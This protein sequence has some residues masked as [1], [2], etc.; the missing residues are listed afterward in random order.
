MTDPTRL[1]HARRA[2]RL[3]FLALGIVAGVWGVHVPSVKATYALDERGLAGVLLATSVGSVLALFV[4]GRLVGRLGT[5]HATV[6]AALAFTIAL[7]VAL[8]LPGLALLLPVMVLFGAGESVYDV[9]INAEG[10]A[11]E[12]M[13]QRPIVSGLHGMFSAGAML[14]SATAA[15]MLRAQ[16][17]PSVQLALVAISVALLVTV[18][19][20]WLL[21]ERVVA[22]SDAAHFVWPSGTLLLLGILVMSGM[23][24]EGVMYNWSVL[25]VAQ[26]LHT[27]Q[28]QAAL[29][30]VAFAG[31]TAATRFIGDA[32]R[33]R[34][35]ER[36]ILLV[37]PLLSAIAMTLVLWVAR[38]WAAYVGFA[39]VGAGLATIVPILYT[40]STRIPGVS[41]AAAIASVSSIGYLGF[42]IGP[43]IIG[44]IAH[45]TT[46]T[47]AMGTLVVA[48]VVVAV[49]AMRVPMPRSEGRAE[50]QPHTAAPIHGG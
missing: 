34:V 42:M 18:S 47:L 48:S 31:A 20:R 44:G 13:S 16:V 41:R 14:G 2:T 6:V 29:A 39:V 11:L 40:A 25:Y 30:Y 50:A 37:G 38:P 32:I 36:V 24:A 43:P 12:V 23:M 46:L 1:S 22:T 28:E 10:T 3:H 26:E 21:T 33:A 19:A 9:S 15:A 17:T 49:G 27:P 5:R 7:A 8:H 35:S 45:A 4:A